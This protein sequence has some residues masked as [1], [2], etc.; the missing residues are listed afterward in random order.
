MLDAFA[1]R[2]HLQNEYVVNLISEN[3]HV[4]L[5]IVFGALYSNSKSH[6]NRQIHNL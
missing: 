2:L 4:I 3:V 1:D 5:P 6:W